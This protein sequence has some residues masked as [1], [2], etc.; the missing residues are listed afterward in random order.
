MAYMQPTV[1]E[2]YSYYMLCLECGIYTIQQLEEKYWDYK[3]HE[4]E[5]LNSSNRLSYLSGQKA[6]ETIIQEHRK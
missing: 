6:L 3:K 5:W 1:S 2:W 4:E